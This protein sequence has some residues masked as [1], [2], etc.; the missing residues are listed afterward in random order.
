MFPK[1]QVPAKL[2][3]IVVPDSLVR[4]LTIF[5]SD[6]LIITSP[7]SCFTLDFFIIVSRVWTYVRIIIL[8]IDIPSAKP[9]IISPFSY[10]KLTFPYTLRSPNW[11]SNPCLPPT[12]EPTPC[13]FPYRSANVWQI[14]STP[15]AGGPFTSLAGQVNA[16]YASWSPLIGDHLHAHEA[17]KC[18][19][20]FAC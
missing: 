8:H 19:R 2:K 4:F 17:A 15:P 14:A 5:D 12:A 13:G 9:P 11:D 7:C 6:F 10:R 3:P 1:K 18:M 16:L 20:V